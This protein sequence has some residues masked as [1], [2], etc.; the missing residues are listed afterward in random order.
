MSP[1]NREAGGAREGSHQPWSWP[2]AVTFG[3]VV[4]L[5]AYFVYTGT[6][7]CP[8]SSQ[9]TSCAGRGGGVWGSGSAGAAH[10][11][12]R[13]CR[14]QLQPGR[15]PGVAVPLGTLWGGRES[16]HS[17]SATSP[18]PGPSSK[19][20]AGGSCACE[21]GNKHTDTSMQWSGDTKVV[22]MSS[23]ASGAQ[24]ERDASPPPQGHSQGQA[25]ISV[26][27]QSQE[28]NCVQESPQR[29]QGWHILL[30]EGGTPTARIRADDKE[31]ESSPPGTLTLGQETQRLFLCHCPIWNLNKCSHTLGRK[32][33]NMGALAGCSEH[34]RMG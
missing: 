12:R 28:D 26:Q 2:W 3:Q 20:L 16:Q 15:G 24:Q 10:R 13:C 7:T 5:G 23:K 11:A 8:G 17:L 25:M 4:T 31:L 9:H 22:F 19:W 6:K 21:P 29:P 32:H 27:P 18:G 34:W 1:P 33:G 14:T 30:H